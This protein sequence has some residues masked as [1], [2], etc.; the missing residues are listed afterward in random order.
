M[1]KSIKTRRCPQC[2][3]VV[4]FTSLK[5]LLEHM[6]SSPMC[7]DAIETCSGCLMHFPDETSL[8]KHLSLKKKCQEIYNMGII[9]P[10]IAS[11]PT[12]SGPNRDVASSVA[13]YYSSGQKRKKINPNDISR[14]DNN[15][16]LTNSFTTYAYQHGSDYFGKSKT[17]LCSATTTQVDFEYYSP[18]VNNNEYDH[19][20]APFPQEFHSHS[21]EE[22]YSDS[23]SDDSDD[24]SSVLDETPSS[25]KDDAVE[26]DITTARDNPK[27]LA[28]MIRRKNVPTINLSPEVQMLSIPEDNRERC[29]PQYI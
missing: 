8:S 2:G 10:S 23:S 19:S 24:S 13:Y 6:E 18:P 22:Q 25:D 29:Q 5:V 17:L 16:H 15:N 28:G 9:D 11:D 1:S 21:T 4:K 12:S 20:S 7:K 14:G 26:A 27:V 3:V